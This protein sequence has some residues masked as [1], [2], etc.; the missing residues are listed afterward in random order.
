MVKSKIQDID[1]NSIGSSSKVVERQD[2]KKEVVDGYKAKHITTMPAA[3]FVAHKDLKKSG[4]TTG[5]FTAYIIEAV[6]E[7]LRR[8]G[9]I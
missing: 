2:Q 6:R 1:I 7:K 4:G 9:A 3:F 5:T 8:D